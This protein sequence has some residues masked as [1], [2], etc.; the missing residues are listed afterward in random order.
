ML[1]R[2]MFVL[3]LSVAVL[4]AMVGSVS[5]QGFTNPGFESGMAP[6]TVWG[7]VTGLTGNTSTASGADV[8]SG[9]YALEYAVPASS[10]G[11]YVKV[12]Q[13]YKGP[14]YR[15][16][17]CQVLEASG[18]VKTTA[19]SPTV[20]IL[21]YQTDDAAANVSYGV[22]GYH[23]GID[24]SSWTRVSGQF[25]PVTNPAS[26]TSPATLQ[27]EY[28]TQDV[29]TAGFTAFWDD[30]SLAVA[31]G[32]PYPC[33]GFE[34]GFMTGDAGPNMPGVLGGG[35]T[36]SIDTTDKIQGAQSFK[37][38]TDAA[39]SAQYIL[40]RYMGGLY[41]VGTKV[42]IG[43]WVKATYAGGTG[44]ALELRRHEYDTGSS[45]T[46]WNGLIASV[47]GNQA[48]WTQMRGN[49]TVTG[50]T[51]NQATPLVSGQ[52][53]WL[54][55]KHATASTTGPSTTWWDG[56]TLRESGFANPDLR[57][58]WAA[59][60]CGVRLRVIPPLLLPRQLM[61]TADFRH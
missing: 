50:G 14:L 24:T 1:N 5:G 39:S 27:I 52:A 46:V 6:W 28:T 34:A 56:I 2:K 44:N 42:E 49:F 7:P 48:S 29:G 9:T 25:V 40:I 4:M 47:A 23:V 61:S 59:G 32:N 53:F 51:P 43:A 16:S 38:V 33:G 12:F 3:V 18:W 31:T 15:R 54:M 57:R 8:H 22:C 26:D 37:H 41:T 60:P 11:T 35:G 58:A 17:N 45:V 30:M 55:L 10:P 19:G 20:H 36:A 13:A 21:A